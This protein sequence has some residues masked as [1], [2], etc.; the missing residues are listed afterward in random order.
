VLDRVGQRLAQRKLDLEL[1]ARGA[2]HLVDGRHDL[3]DH[4]RNGVD[5]GRQRQV[6]LDQEVAA[7]E[8]ALR[9]R[10]ARHVLAPGLR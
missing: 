7:V 2:T 10:L 3:L 4:G 9:Q 1:P 8:L 6:Y 5:V